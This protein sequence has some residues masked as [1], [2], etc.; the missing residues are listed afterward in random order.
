[1]SLLNKVKTKFNRI[2]GLIASKIQSN[3][4]NINTNQNSSSLNK[5]LET[6]INKF[7]FP[8]ITKKIKQNKRR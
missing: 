5:E 3:K 7:G 4:S 6:K 1:M 2:Y 8:I